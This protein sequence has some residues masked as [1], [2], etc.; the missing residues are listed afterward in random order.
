MDLWIQFKYKRLVDICFKCG[1]LGHWMK[2]E[3]MNKRTTQWVESLDETDQTKDE[4]EEE[5]GRH[6]QLELDVHREHAPGVAS[7]KVR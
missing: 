1:R 3:T 5:R 6:L 4:E 7:T 2:A